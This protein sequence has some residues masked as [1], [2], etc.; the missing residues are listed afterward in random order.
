MDGVLIF[1]GTCDMT[2]D[3]IVRG[4]RM[5]ERE[6]ERSYNAIRDKF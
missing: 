4:E 2:L 3:M 5:R 6:R 1:I